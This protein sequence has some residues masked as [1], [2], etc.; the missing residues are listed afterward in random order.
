MNALLR[1][2]APSITALTFLYSGSWAQSPATATLTWT[3]VTTNTNGTTIAVAVAYNVYQGA[4]GA[5]LA[6][7]QSGVAGTTAT[8]TAGLIAGTT[9]CFA[10]TAVVGTSESAQSNT[11]CIA[12]PAAILVPNA[13][14]N[15]QVTIK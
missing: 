9:Q 11:A 4:K 5:T 12:V 6:K 8:V 14:Q 2:T 7:V 15:V 10:V 13:P 1:M 3:A